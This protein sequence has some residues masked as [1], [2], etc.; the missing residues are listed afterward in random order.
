MERGVG[1]YENANG[2]VDGDNDRDMD[3]DNDHDNN[4]DSIREAPVAGATKVNVSNLSIA[5][6]P[7]LTL[8]IAS[9]L[10]LV[11]P[12]VVVYSPPS[13]RVVAYEPKS[14]RKVRGGPSWVGK[15]TKI[16]SLFFCFIHFFFIVYL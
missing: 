13:L 6:N 4:R 7:A 9:D 1:G 14:R 8:D 15:L 10:P 16:W 11:T 2:D 5:L 12:P 3:H